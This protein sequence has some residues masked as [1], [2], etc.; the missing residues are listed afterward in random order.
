MTLLGEQQTEA[1]SWTSQGPTFN[2][3]CPI[4]IHSS[5]FLCHAF[6]DLLIFFNF[7]DSAYYLQESR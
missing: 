5:S 2:L 4:N 6:R 7:S 1:V 3:W